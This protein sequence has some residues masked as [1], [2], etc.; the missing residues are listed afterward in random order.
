MN[1][2]YQLSILTA[3]IWKPND[4]NENQFGKEDEKYFITETIRRKGKEERED[5]LTEMGL[6]GEMT[7]QDGLAM[8]VDLGATWC[9]FRKVKK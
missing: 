5:L 7:E 1:T 4:S 9:M 8:L 6:G 3:L 2:N